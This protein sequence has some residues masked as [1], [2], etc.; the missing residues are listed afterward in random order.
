MLFRSRAQFLARVPAGP[1]SSQPV[2]LE[3]RQGRESVDPRLWLK[4]NE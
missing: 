2:Y 3:L 4:K 1:G